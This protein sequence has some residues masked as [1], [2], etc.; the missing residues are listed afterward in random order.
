MVKE[1]KKAPLAHVQ[2]DPGLASPQGLAQAGSADAPVPH[3]LR[4]GRPAPAG[5]LPAE[6]LRQAA[7]GGSRMGPGP[8][9]AGGSGLGARHAAKKGRMWGP[10][11]RQ[12]FADLSE[13]EK[14]GTF[15][16]AKHALMPM[17]F[18]KHPPLCFSRRISFN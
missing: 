6:P 10:R 18:I 8:G 2:T 11:R 15:K 7:K 17:M 3:L 4:G 1:K 14:F 5:G 12:D 13:G 9:E 16:T